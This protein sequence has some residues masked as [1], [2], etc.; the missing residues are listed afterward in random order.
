[1][2]VTSTGLGKPQ[3]MGQVYEAFK[4]LAHMR[5]PKARIKRMRRWVCSRTR[6]AC[7]Y[8]HVYIWYCDSGWGTSPSLGCS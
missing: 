5:R 1:V 2:R 4:S 8:S 6:R 7:R 3:D